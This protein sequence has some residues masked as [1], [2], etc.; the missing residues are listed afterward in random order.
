LE[1]RRSVDE[2]SA[3]TLRAFLDRAEIRELLMRYGSA[4][5]RRDFDSVA[6]CFTPAAT[7]RGSLGEGSIAIALAA[8]RERAQRY[9]TTMHFIGTQVV[10]LD[11][12]RARSRTTALV[13]HRLGGEDLTDL[14][15]GVC[16]DDELERVAGRWLI[17][18]RVA[19]LQWQRFDAVV[20][21]PTEE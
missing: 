7:Y 21:P 11:G 20:L 10:D 4:V 12:D 8:L 18:A 13:Y 16:Y 5:D 14:V 3:Q 15:V 2:P 1:L 9:Q 6:A 17:V 19:T